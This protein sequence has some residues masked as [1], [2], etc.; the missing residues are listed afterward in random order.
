MSKK[1]INSLIKK[2]VQIKYPKRVDD[3]YK[4]LNKM[5]DEKLKKYEKVTFVSSGLMWQDNKE[6][7]TLKFNT[8]EAIM[9]CKNLKLATKKD[10]RLP[11][12]EELLALINYFRVNPAKVD[13][14]YYAVSDRYWTSSMV[15][16]DVS[17]NWYID[18]KYGE[19]GAALKDIKYN[20]RCVRTMSQNPGEF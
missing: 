3:Y 8:I 7:E 5:R 2:Y 20:V 18:F 16:D 15:I 4:K 9:Y 17:A 11:S 10:W 13:G 14:I 19:T 1:D 6:T 12:Y